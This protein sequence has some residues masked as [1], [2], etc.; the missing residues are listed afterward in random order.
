M[1]DKDFNP[2]LDDHEDEVKDYI[3]QDRIAQGLD[4]NGEEIEPMSPLAQHTW[5]T[6]VAINTMVK[7]QLCQ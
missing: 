2:G 5:D 1:I 6:A 7:E 3:E 4:E